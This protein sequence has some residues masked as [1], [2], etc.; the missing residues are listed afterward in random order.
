MIKSFKCKETKRIFDREGSIKFRNIEKVVLRKLL[1][2]AGAG[3]IQ[4]LKIPPANHLE[5]LSGNRKG[6]Y[7]IR[8]N[9]Q[10]RICFIW[11]DGHAYSVEV[12]DYH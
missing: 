7:S 12:V 10:F 2:I 9:D 3:R 8:V 5:K 4:D 11:D 6:Q 1:L